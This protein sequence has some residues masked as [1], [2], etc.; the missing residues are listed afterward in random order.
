[1][2]YA[3]LPSQ[4]AINLPTLCDEIDGYGAVAGKIMGSGAEIIVYEE[5]TP[6]G[7]L[8]GFEQCPV[9]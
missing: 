6:T 5:L 3:L 8:T 7:R 1:V 9:L 4:K 2:I